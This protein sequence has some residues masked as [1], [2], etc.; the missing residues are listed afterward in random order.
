MVTGLCFLC[1]GYVLDKNSFPGIFQGFFLFVKETSFQKHIVG[2]F[3]V[4]LSKIAVRWI[5]QHWYFKIKSVLM[6]KRLRRKFI[7]E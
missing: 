6:I 2:R 7:K 4:L 1:L 5:L 3:P